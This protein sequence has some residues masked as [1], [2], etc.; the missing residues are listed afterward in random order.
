VNRHGATEAPAAEGGASPG[1]TVA[2]LSTASLSPAD[3][4]E[5]PIRRVDAASGAP[6]I[7]QTWPIASG[8]IVFELRSDHALPST[9]FAAIG[10]VVAQMEAL[11]TSLSAEIPAGPRDEI[12]P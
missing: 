5:A 12:E 11:S 4:V 7:R 2:P 10:E 8:E 1:S 3:A 6:T 9:A